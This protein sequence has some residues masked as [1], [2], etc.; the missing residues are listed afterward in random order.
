M[1]IAWQAAADLRLLPVG[2]QLGWEK[3]GKGKLDLSR[4][5]RQDLCVELQAY[6]ALQ[7]SICFSHQGD[8]CAA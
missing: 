8:T 2:K 4:E 6:E 5:S 3:R 7:R 1:A